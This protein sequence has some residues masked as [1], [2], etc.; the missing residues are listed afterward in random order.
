MGTD[1]IRIPR[2]RAGHEAEYARLRAVALAELDLLEGLEPR[3][4]SDETYRVEGEALAAVLR[5]HQISVYPSETFEVFLATLWDEARGTLRRQGAGSLPEEHRALL[6][7]T[8]I[9]EVLGALDS[10][11]DRRFQA[12]EYLC[13]I[14]GDCRWRLTRYTR[15]ELHLLCSGWDAGPVW[16]GYNLAPG[17]FEGGLVPYPGVT[18]EQARAGAL[19]IHGQVCEA[20]RRIVPA[21][22]SFEDARMEAEFARWSEFRWRATFGMLECC[23]IERPAWV[24]TLDELTGRGPDGQRDRG[25]A[26]G[27]AQSVEWA[28]DAFG[29]ARWMEFWGSR[30]HGFRVC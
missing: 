22:R 9:H 10:R 30:G 17:V 27:V 2:P 21:L 14:L 18:A 4:W 6:A 25:L 13:D 16:R 26:S 11:F 15:R 20:L 23:P 28:I 8:G 12:H 1:W 19:R 24:D 7:S 3:D 5:L 29:A